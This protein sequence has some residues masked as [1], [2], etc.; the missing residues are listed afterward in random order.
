MTND[1]A[2]LVVQQKRSPADIV[3]SQDRNNMADSVPN[4]EPKIGG[5]TLKS[6]KGNQDKAESRQRFDQLVAE[7][8]EARRSRNS[9]NTLKSAGDEDSPPEKVSVEKRQAEPEAKLSLMSDPEANDVGAI[10]SIP[11]IA[12][13]PSTNVAINRIA[14]REAELPQSVVENV[15]EGARLFID[16]SASL[17]LP[18]NRHQAPHE[19]LTAAQALHQA[20]SGRPLP[21]STP[22]IDPAPLHVDPTHETIKPPEDVQHR[23]PSAPLAMRVVVTDGSMGLAP[24]RPVTPLGLRRSAEASLSSLSHDSPDSRFVGDPETADPDGPLFQRQEPSPPLPMVSQMRDRRA[25]LASGRHVVQA[26]ASEPHAQG[27]LSRA[28][29]SMESAQHMQQT[30][31][32]ALLRMKQPRP[33]ARSH[34]PA[35]MDQV[36]VHIKRAVR[37]GLDRIHIQ[38]KPATLGR[39]D[40]TMEVGQ[41]G[42]VL[43]VVEANK[44]ETLDMLIQDAE[45]L[46]R[47]LREAGLD[48]GGLTFAFKDRGG[49]GDGSAT[50]DQEVASRDKGGD[51]K[52]VSDDGNTSSILM[53][54][55]RVRSV[56]IQV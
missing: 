10:E 39:V 7:S 47:A 37:V 2:A 41:D 18:P 11:F 14:Y 42:R 56:D 46:Q 36:A 22:Q 45:S 24:A 53:A 4:S 43:A 13:D 20:V 44:A 25:V 54:W 48:P 19:R 9:K 33:P 52:D 3:H 16:E 29:S 6:R 26:K 28:D 8:I 30:R 34:H 50:T 32:H 27:S 23:Q 35:L 17:G 21:S 55:G 1:L 38:L 49:E 40:V 51:E 5:A 15:A 31:E 12:D